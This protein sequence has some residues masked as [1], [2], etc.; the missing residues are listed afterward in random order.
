VA[1]H[2]SL[3]PPPTA[4]T[5]PAATPARSLLR[6]GSLSLLRLRSLSLLRLGC[7]GLPW[8]LLPACLLSHRRPA[9]AGV[10]L[11]CVGFQ[12]WFLS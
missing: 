9:A 8:L 2:L 11:C 12:K 5:I 4:A 3:R 6:L 10:I 7:L 1:L